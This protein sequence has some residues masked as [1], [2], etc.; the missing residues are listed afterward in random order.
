MSNWDKVDF[1]PKDVK[2]IMR[3][4][5]SLCNEVPPQ[6]I[7]ALAASQAGWVIQIDKPK[8]SDA[9]VQGMVVGTKRYVRSHSKK[10]KKK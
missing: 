5:T 9:I 7:I 3:R 8:R 4:V 2:R 10:E 1:T 6:L